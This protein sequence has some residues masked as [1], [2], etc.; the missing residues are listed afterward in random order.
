MK[1][2]IMIMALL[3]V[4]A[5]GIGSAVNWLPESTVYGDLNI[6][7]GG[8]IEA[9]GGSLINASIGQ[10]SQI[11]TVGPYTWCDYTT[12]GSSDQTEINTATAAH[13]IVRVVGSISVSGTIYAR[14]GKELIID[15]DITAAE[16]FSGVGSPLD[17]LVFVA[18]DN[19][20]ISGTGT[21]DCAYR[22]V[23]A[24]HSTYPF[25]V[26]DITITRATTGIIIYS[27]NGPSRVRCVNVED[28]ASN[29]IEIGGSSRNSTVSGCKITNSSSGGISLYGQ[30]AIITNNRIIGVSG[31]GGGYGIGGTGA[32]RC[33]IADNVIRNTHLES[34]LLISATDCTVSGNV[35]DLS[36]SNSYD[37]GLTIDKCVYTSVVGNVVKNPQLS[38]IMV[39]SCNGCVVV[40][41]I[42]IDPARQDNRDCPYDSGI[43]VKT[44]SQLC[45]VT[46]NTIHDSGGKIIHAI[47]EYNSGVKN[48]ITLNTA[49]GANITGGGQLIEGTGSLNGTLLWSTS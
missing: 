47:W 38:G 28:S 49:F 23:R 17:I 48:I 20:I 7:G 29:G 37:L 18:G 45:I 16:G 13:D 10:S 2:K 11:Y 9:N 42:I 43:V 25:N 33:T 24:I 41:N 21:L 30:D 12:D 46:G 1:L 35:A 36:G 14:G 6:A 5:V 31:G 3:L 32:D 8:N 27:T 22:A 34:I 15:G 19:A 39:T 26:D 4:S 44:G 40:G